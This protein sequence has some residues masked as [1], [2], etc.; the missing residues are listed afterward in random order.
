MKILLVDDD[1][2][3]REATGALLETDGHEVTAVANGREALAWLADQQPDLVVTDFE[4]PEMD[5]SALIETMRRDHPEVPALLISGHPDAASEGRRLGVRTLA[6]PVPAEILLATVEGVLADDTLRSTA[7]VAPRSRILGRGTVRTQGSR[8][9]QGES[10]RGRRYGAALASA[11]AAGLALFVLM[12]PRAPQLPDPPTS[13]VVRGGS[14]ELLDPLGPLG[15]SPRQLRWRASSEA[16]QHRVMLERVDDQIFFEE[17]LAHDPSASE[18]RFELP[19]ELVAGFVPMVV[20]HWRVEALDIQGRVLAQSERGRFRVLSDPRDSETA[21]SLA[22]PSD[23]T[24]SLPS[25]NP[26]DLP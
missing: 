4:M 8:P 16:S 17:T 21:P 10:G 7:P 11:L 13:G 26:G 1:P 9:R 24:P 5:G 22:P 23:P 12:G 14:V 2:E 19:V 25:D 3:E 20:Y 15:A 6:K 18:Q